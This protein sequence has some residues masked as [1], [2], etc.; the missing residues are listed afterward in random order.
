ML[1]SSTSG[2]FNTFPDLSHFMCRNSH[3][4]KVESQVCSFA[5]NTFRVIV[6]LIRQVI[7]GES[8]PV[9]GTLNPDTYKVHAFM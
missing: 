7:Y 9:L 5:V 8:F 1:L 2:L 3:R 6:S 4:G